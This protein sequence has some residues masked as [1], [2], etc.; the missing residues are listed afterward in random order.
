MLPGNDV[1]I[2]TRREVLQKTRWRKAAHCSICTSTIWFHPIALKEPLGAPEPRR[3]WV[4]CRSCHEALL[5]EMHRSPVRSP[6]RLRIALGLVAAERSPRA[7]GLSTHVRDQR[8]FVGIIWVLIIAMLLHLVVV[9][10]LATM[11]K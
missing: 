1:S 9:V 11:M 10:I 6:M 8:R 4:L 3:E 2:V 5:L 7:Y